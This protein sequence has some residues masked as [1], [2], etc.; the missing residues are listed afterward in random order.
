VR[1][2]RTME[3][4]ESIGITWCLEVL[5]AVRRKTTDSVRRMV[6]K[7]LVAMV[8]SGDVRSIRRR[9]RNEYYIIVPVFG[10]FP[11]LI[12]LIF[13]FVLGFLSATTDRPFVLS[14]RTESVLVTV[15]YS[16]R[17]THTSKPKQL[18]AAFTPAGRSFLTTNRTRHCTIQKNQSSIPRHLH[19]IRKYQSHLFITH[20]VADFL[21]KR[22]SKS[23]IATASKPS[24]PS[25]WLK[26]PPQTN[27]SASTPRSQS[28]APT[29]APPHSHLTHS[30]RSSNLSQSATIK[31]AVSMPRNNAGSGKQGPSCFPCF[32]FLFL[33]YLLG[34]AVMFGSIDDPS[35]SFSP[36]PAAKSSLIKP[37]GVNPSGPTPPPSGQANGIPPVSS[38]PKPS[39]A[40]SPPEAT[41]ATPTTATPKTKIDVRKFFQSSSSDQG[42]DA[43]SS[44]PRP[45]S[46]PSQQQQP[47]SSQLPPGQ[48]V[49]QPSPLSAQ[50]PFVPGDLRQQQQNGPGVGP[51]P[52]PRSPVVYP[53]Q[54]TN[55]TGPRPSAG[56]S[57]P[58]GPPSAMS[59]GLSSPRLAP[60]PHPSQPSPMQSTPVI[61]VP[62]WPGYFVRSFSRDSLSA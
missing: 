53:R 43:A 9:L 14:F 31:D 32:P 12:F 28:P 39:V 49:P 36:S 27:S 13:F 24:P 11:H 55:G 1:R 62:G 54:M 46:L 47:S 17:P 60:M 7:F 59:A 20:F 37:D 8:V 6:S 5:S 25:V 52:G 58:G 38:S 34:S 10:V 18:L 33:H 16:Q 22:M 51:G 57:G 2:P 40:P 26:G 30:R 23:S 3:G 45:P 35:T 50:Y 48:P 21:Q 44:S 19:K 56:P 29:N 15:R 61:P 4:E 41:P 42:S